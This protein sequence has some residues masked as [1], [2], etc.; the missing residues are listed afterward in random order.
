MNGAI[1]LLFLNIQLLTVNVTK[2]HSLISYALLSFFFSFHYLML[3]FKLHNCLSL[4]SLGQLFENK[5]FYT[6]WNFIQTIKYY[7]THSNYNLSPEKAC[8]KISRIKRDPGTKPSFTK[9]KTVT[10]ARR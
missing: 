7:Y 8:T 10:V 9:H 3:Y 1:I 4:F 5:L 6:I 2:V